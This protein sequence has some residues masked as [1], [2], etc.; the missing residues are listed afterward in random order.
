MFCTNTFHSPLSQILIDF[1]SFSALPIYLNQVHELNLPPSQLGYCAIHLYFTVSSFISSCYLLIAMTFERFYSII[2]PH[3]ASLLNTV[4]RAKITIASI[5]VFSFSFAIPYLFVVGTNGRL[6]IANRFA[7]NNVLGEFYSWSTDILFFIIPFPSLLVMNSVI[8]YTLRK[9][10]RSN[11]SESIGQIQTDPKTLKLKNSEKQ[12]L[13][14][15]LLIT[16]AF[17]ILNMP[18]RVLTYYLNFYSGD[19]P[20]F[21][22]GLYLFYQVG[23]KCH[24]TN[25]GI[26]LFLYVLSGQKFRT[27]L[28]NLFRFKKSSHNDIFTSNVNSMTTS[29]AD[30]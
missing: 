15:V 20:Y 26:N 30:D 9:R 28:K 29:V 8:I 11:I 16:F 17:L 2:Q 10:S 21:Q 23:E 25:H 3:K 6:C 22:A 4:K 24:Y 1:L 12:V 18:A 7:S 5:F 19:T 13:T 14:M 27:D